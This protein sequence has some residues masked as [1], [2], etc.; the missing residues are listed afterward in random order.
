MNRTFW[1]QSQLQRNQV[2]RGEVFIVF[3][4]QSGNY[5]S[6]PHRERIYKTSSVFLTVDCRKFGSR[7]L[8]KNADKGLLDMVVE[9]LFR[10]LKSY[11]M[12]LSLENGMLLLMKFLLLR[13]LDM[14]LFCKRT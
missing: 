5:K 9:I 2:T 7:E 11:G 10:E 14:W 4:L 12:R 6:S 8:K 3:D 1:D 13:L